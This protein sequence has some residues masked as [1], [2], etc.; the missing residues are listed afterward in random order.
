MIVIFSSLYDSA[1]APLSQSFY[2]L[3]QCKFVK[4]VNM[5]H[6]LIVHVFVLDAVANQFHFAS[7]YSLLAL[8]RKNGI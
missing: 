7:R 6:R 3:G 4:D 2:S 8:V 5:H 1:V